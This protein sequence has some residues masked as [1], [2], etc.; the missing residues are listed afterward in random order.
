MNHRRLVLR[1]LLC[2]A[3]LLLAVAGGALAHEVPARVL[4]SAFVKPEGDALNVLV[5]VPLAAMR[6]LSLPRHGPGYLDIEAA[7]PLLAD[8]AMLWIGNEMRFFEGAR[9][10]GEGQLQA[11]RLS[12]PSDG[13]F[14]D[15][16]QARAHLAG[17][18]LP[19]ETQ[20][21]W[22][23]GLLDVAFRYAITSDTAAFAMDAGFA[24]LGVRTVTLLRFLPPTGPERLFQYQGD[25]GRV[26]LDPRWHQAAGRFV[27]L[28]FAHVLE[29]VDH[30]LFVFCLVIPFRRI[31]PLVML[32]TAF[33]VAHS[34][35][36]AAAA[37][38]MAP[39]GGW[40]PPLIEAL[41]AASIV[42]M[43]VENLFSPRLERRWLMAFGFGLIH[44]FGFAFVLGDALQF[45]GAHLAVSL[46]AFN[47]GIEL[48]QLLVV[49][50]AVPLLSLAFSRGL[51]R[52]L[53]IIV[54]SVLVA[55][56][57]WHWLLERGSEFLAHPFPWPELDAAGWAGAM[58][59]LL[60]FLV[61]F[62]A[63]WLLHLGY[64]R[65]MRVEGASP[66]L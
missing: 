55:H 54:L 53:G 43:A 38:G 63:L 28:G 4:V 49:A 40:F 48:G 56:T 47:L 14:V 36:L 60:L 31:R 35:T 62:G 13:S 2:S 37:M 41:I 39:Q 26:A 16:A 3:S 33:T 20:L 21:Y 66:E 65:W 12:L 45:A 11:V 57:G 8:A 18:P 10:L 6:D 22:E 42:Y 9:D 15:Y 50:I 19:A 61:T 46:A 23:Q 58:R 24:H 34:V 29:G 44:G 27:L 25:P 17:P 30:L 64:R 59:W 1:A 52:R 5:R 32:V 51:P 7:Q